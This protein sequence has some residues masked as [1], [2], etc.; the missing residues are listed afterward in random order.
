M[1]KNQIDHWLILLKNPRVQ[2]FG[3]LI[4]FCITI[5]ISS[6]A[7]L[8]PEIFRTHDFVHGVRISEMLDALRDGHFP[9]RW[10]QNLGYGYGMP[11]FEFYAP[12]P[13]YVGAFFYWLTNNLLFASK[14][15]WLIPSVVGFIGTY[16]YVSRHYGR[17][18]G[19]V[20]AVLFTLAPYRAV[21][22]Y[23]RGALSEVWAMSF[24]P[25]ILYGVDK[26]TAQNQ[27][28]PWITL[29]LANVGLFLSH[30]LMT[31]FFTP[32]VL[33]YA[34]LAFV[35]TKG[36]KVRV[37]KDIVRAFVLSIGTSAFYIFPA[38][39]EKDYTQVSSR[40]LSGYF[41]YSQHFLY[42]RQFFQENWKYG[43]SQ[44]GPN[45]DISFFLGYPQLVL[46][47]LSLV[48]I[49]IYFI[50]S[51]KKVVLNKLVLFG[52]L[53]FSLLASL[54]LSTQKSQLIWNIPTLQ[55]A[56]FPW[57][58]LALSSFFIACASGISFWIIKK[59]MYR[60]SLAVLIIGY[61]FF[62]GVTYFQPEFFLDNSE[63][64]YY[65]DATRIQN[66]MSE[67]LPDYMPIYLAENIQPAELRVEVVGLEEE[68][69]QR[70]VLVDRTHEI[71]VRM[72]FS[73]ERVLRFNVA[74]YPGWTVSLDGKDVPH[75]RMAVGTIEV[76]VPPGDHLVGLQLRSTPVRMWSDL[77]AL[78]SA[79]VT[80]YMIVELRKEKLKKPS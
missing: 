57:R 18:A 53:A 56:Q 52:F 65:S 62:K 1:K 24:F 79:I 64:L 11:L 67:T 41:H 14:F 12:L 72:I 54:L 70:E 4:I 76:K 22:L 7:L 16:K 51:K 31:L 59:D 47:A 44:W 28:K 43:G 3:V 49:F 42:I 37:L 66:E 34:G 80:L 9:V 20:A 46:F 2:K 27:K 36:K 38:L 77:I 40:I 60:Y 8:N 35:R 69:R 63:A 23:V 45:D 68:R 10:S 71:L 61:T 55:V 73:G 48:V 30:N 25:W 32:V 78:L 58:F 15:L 17:L 74:D 75:E 13:F 50:Q 39:L 19:L 33:A 21:N 29:F 26:I 5:F 6:R